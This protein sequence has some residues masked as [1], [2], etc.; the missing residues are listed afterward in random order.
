MN[1]ELFD[2]GEDE[3]RV[4]GSTSEESNPDKKPSPKGKRRRPQWRW[5]LWLSIA[6]LLNLACLAYWMMMS[7]PTLPPSTWSAEPFVDSTQNV[8]Y[9]ATVEASAYVE[10]SRDSI[11]DIALRIYAP[12]GGHAELLVGPLPND[13][14]SI[15]LAAQAADYRADNGQI[16]GAFVYRGELLSRG[17]P[18]YGFCAIIGDKLTMGMSSETALFE[19]AV[20][21]EGY[22]FRQF[23]LVHD[24]GHG[25]SVPKGKSVRR[26]LCYYRESIVIIESVERESMH[27]FSTA[28]IDLGVQEAI[29]LVGNTE[30]TLYEDEAGNRFT[31]ETGNGPDVQETYIIW[32]R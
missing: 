25:E 17:H 10:M 29:A 28:L 16:A 22:F 4:V 27:D 32:R 15:I 19:R 23:S 11:N 26:A 21:Q 24:A 1:K 3:I 6:L 30:L 5:W 31:G 14:R 8:T 18:K 20:E 13:D 2:I 7:R 12:V 9:E